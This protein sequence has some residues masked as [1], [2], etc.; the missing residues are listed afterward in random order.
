MWSMPRLLQ[1]IALLL[2]PEFV[3][4]LHRFMSTRVETLSSSLL[5]S[6]GSI[7]KRRPTMP[8]LRNVRWKPALSG[9]SKIE[10]NQRPQT[11]ATMSHQSAPDQWATNSRPS[12]RLTRNTTQAE[13]SKLIHHL[14]KWIPAFLSAMRPL[15]FYFV[16]LFNFFSFYGR[17]TGWHGGRFLF[18]P[19]PTFGDGGTNSHF[20]KWYF[21]PKAVSVTLLTLIVSQYV[22]R[23]LC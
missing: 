13:E 3:S 22:T 14:Y 7:S 11:V 1:P 8:I 5:L 17:K 2:L 21:T 12:F 6:D 9:K 23:S 15:L 20:D 18:F 10:R 19:L 16:P 4:F